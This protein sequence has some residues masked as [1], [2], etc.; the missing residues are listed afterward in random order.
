ME[1]SSIAARHQSLLSNHLV[2][3]GL[4]NK[5]Q[6]NVLLADQ[7]ATLI[8]FSEIVIQRGWLKEQTINYFIRTLQHS[9]PEF[10]ADIL[11]QQIAELRQQRDTLRN[12]KNALEQEMESLRLEKE[13]LKR[14]RQ[15]TAA[16]ARPKANAQAKEPSPNLRLR[17]RL[18]SLSSKDSI[19]W[20]D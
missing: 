4:L 8:P 16:Q 3:A 14:S 17:S 18:R 19:P 15:S 11:S 20:C 9:E 13:A 7:A 5:A 12:I 1:V 10:S 2:E 6:V